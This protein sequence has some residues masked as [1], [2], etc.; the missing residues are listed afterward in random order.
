MSIEQ[1]V[2]VL[3]VFSPLIVAAYLAHADR[4]HLKDKGETR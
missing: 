1:V 2:S 4:C 3:M